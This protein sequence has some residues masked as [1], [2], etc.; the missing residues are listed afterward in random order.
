MNT[1]GIVFPMWI[2]GSSVVA[3]FGAA[4]MDKVFLSNYNAPLSYQENFQDDVITSRN[5]QFPTSNAYFNVD[6]AFTKSTITRNPIATR[7]II[8]AT[9]VDERGNTFISLLHHNLFPIYA[10][11]AQFE[12][13]YNFFPMNMI[14]HS[15]KATRFSYGFS[16]F[17]TDLAR[18]NDNTFGSIE[19]EYSNNIWANW[20]PT[21]SSGYQ[22]IRFYFN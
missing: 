21:I 3:F 14:D 16:K 13:I 4:S 7:W 2:S 18:M 6:R 11:I 9:S 15:R 10:S 17:F 20:T 5:I 1:N 12:G 8:D 19:A 22:E